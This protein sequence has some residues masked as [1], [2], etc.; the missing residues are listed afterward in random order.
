MC[1]YCP[2]GGISKASSA[3]VERDPSTP[4]LETLTT[5]RTQPA[6]RH[7]GVGLQGSLLW[8]LLVTEALYVLLKSSPCQQHDDANWYLE[9]TPAFGCPKCQTYL[10]ETTLEL[11]HPAHRIGLRVGFRGCRQRGKLR[12]LRWNPSGCSLVDLF[13]GGEKLLEPPSSTVQ[14]PS[15]GHHLRCTTFRSVSKCSPIPFETRHQT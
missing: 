15:L 10:R 4:V 14:S 3:G 6:P 12:R 2:S 5:T 7:S 1:A 13:A 8:R 11:R 9:Q